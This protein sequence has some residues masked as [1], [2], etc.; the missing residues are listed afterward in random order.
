M[1]RRRAEHA[2]RGYRA[3]EELDTRPAIVYL[4]EVYRRRDEG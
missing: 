4:R 2:A 3:L 1:M